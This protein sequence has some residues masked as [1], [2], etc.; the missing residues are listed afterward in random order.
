MLEHLNM[1]SQVRSSTAPIVLGFSG[2]KDSVAMVLYLLEQGIPKERI[3]LHHHDVDGGD[4]RL[5]DWQCT[6]SYCKSFAKALGLKLFFSYRK[7]GIRRAIYRTEEAKQ[8]IYYQIE[9][10]GEFHMIPSDKNF[11]NTRR[12]FPAVA[13]DLRTRWCSAEA[14]IEVIRSVIAHHPSYQK[15]LWVLTGERRQEGR[16][17]KEGNRTGRA[18]YNEIELHATNGKKRS[19]V[20]WRPIIDWTEEEVWGIMERHNIQPHPAYMLGWSR[21]SCQICIFNHSDIWSKIYEISPDKVEQIGDIEIDLGFT[22]Y[23][24]M[25]IYQKVAKGNLVDNMDPYWIEQALGEFT[26][27]IIVKDWV[28]P[29]GA[30]KKESAGAI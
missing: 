4:A 16:V 19:V 21:C 11:I 29:S 28:I 25:N 24:K 14:K 23:N 15:S 26:A 2:G 10:D 9:P 20:A 1:L 12:R 5:F 17:S 7:G 6:E 27:P 3:H 30:F 13:A 18:A 22:L 8:D